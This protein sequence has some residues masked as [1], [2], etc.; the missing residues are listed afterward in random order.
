MTDGLEF[1]PLI[2]PVD[3]GIRDRWPVTLRAGDLVL[4][5]VLGADRKTWEALKLANASWTAEWDATQPP[6]AAKPPATFGT[7]VRQVNRAARRGDIMPWVMALATPGGRAKAA[8]L[9]M[10]GQ[11]TVSGISYGSARC[12][13][14]GYWIDQAHAGRGY[15]PL[16]VGLAGDFCF[17][18]LRLHRLEI[19]I[20][21]E[22]GPSL[23]VVQKLGF[24]D[25][26]MRPAFLHVNRAWRDHRI[27]ALNA[28][29]AAD[30]LINRLDWP[31]G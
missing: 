3:F 13:A 24:R 23:R 26:G 16:A 1:H 12:A 15:T 5:P 17:R 29:E 8:S 28:D 14:I 7:W 9:S 27:F 6:E 30:G 4:R 18:V 31:T 22:N 11:V 21:P 10:I 25:E 2:G 19:A 20:R